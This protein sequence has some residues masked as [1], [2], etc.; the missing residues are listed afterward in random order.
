MRFGRQLRQAQPTHADAQP[1]DVRGRRRLR[2]HHDPVLQGPELVDD[3][4][5]RLHGSRSRCSSGSRCSSP[6]SPRA[7]PKGAARRRPTRCARHGRRPWRTRRSPGDHR[8]HA[9]TALDL[10]DE[11]VV[12]AGEW[13]PSDGEVIEGIRQRRATR[14][15]PGSRHRHPGERGDR[16]AVTGRTRVLSDGS[17]CAHP[18]L[19][20]ARRSSTG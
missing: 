9:G 6:T 4:P 5:E 15:S 3:Q 8:G 14:P 11:C 13:I 7:I 19:A 10:D 1:G 12:T 17:S 16:S 18:R 20:P 2:A